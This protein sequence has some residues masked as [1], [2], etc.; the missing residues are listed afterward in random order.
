MK[1]SLDEWGFTVGGNQQGAALNDRSS[2]PWMGTVLPY[3]AVL[4]E[5]PVKNPRATYVGRMVDLPQHTTVMVQSLEQGWFKLEAVVDGKTYHGY[6][7]RELI[8]YVSPKFNASTSSVAQYRSFLKAESWFV[9]AGLLTQ[10]SE[11]DRQNLLKELSSVQLAQMM[12]AAELPVLPALLPKAL[13]QPGAFSRISKTITELNST[14]A[15]TGKRWAAA[16]RKRGEVEAKAAVSVVSRATW[17]ALERK[18]DKD[19]YEYPAQAPLPLTQI[20]IHHTTDSLKQTVKELQVKEMNDGY[21]DMP[22]HFV[23]TS[24]G[25][26]NEGRIIG[27]MGAHAGQFDG[28]KDKKKDPDYGSI[29]IVLSGDFENRWENG[30]NPDKPTARQLESLQRLLNHLVLEYKIDPNKI[31]RHSEVKRSGKPKV[32]PGANLSLSIDAMKQKARDFL[33]EV[34][35]AE[36]E[37]RTAEQLALQPTPGRNTGAQGA[38]KTR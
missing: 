27:A 22:Y 20:V 16:R 15:A 1:M 10:F 2:Y 8:R 35:T 34:D 3:S 6:V 32:C 26:I 33:N 18:A 11:V 13:F 4:R 36:R 19:W 28:N 21:S 9:A 12:N 38:L 5:K 37:L 29:G 25:T 7:S 31:L 30:W 23:I 24:D 17:G 14:A